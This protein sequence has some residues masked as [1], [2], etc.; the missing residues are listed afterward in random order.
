MVTLRRIDARDAAPAG[1]YP[2]PAGAIAM[3][4]AHSA[5]PQPIRLAELREP[6]I[7]ET[8][9]VPIEQSYPHV[10]GAI[11]RECGDGSAQQRV[12]VLGIALA[13]RGIA[14]E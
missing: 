13:V 1:P 2:H 4:I 11:F 9:H 14:L 8:H 12:S 6:T 5:R 10:P 3:N 7:A